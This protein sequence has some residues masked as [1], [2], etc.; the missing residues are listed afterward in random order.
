M[1]D[2]VQIVEASRSVMRATRTPYAHPQH[3]AAQPPVIAII[4][5]F[6]G[7]V[8]KKAMELIYT[9]QKSGWKLHSAGFGVLYWR[10]CGRRPTTSTTFS[11]LHNPRTLW[12]WLWLALL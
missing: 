10:W 9:I 5:R 11:R 7:G 8:V 6:C 12:L 3:E 1:W 2:T 4:T